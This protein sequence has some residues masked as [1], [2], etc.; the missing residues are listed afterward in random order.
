MATP[1]AAHVLV[2]DDDPIV[3]QLVTESLRLSGHHTT[4]VGGA[5]E[6]LNV[7][8]QVEFDLVLTDALVGA[9]AEPEA[10]RWENLEYVRR[11]AGHARVVIFS[12]HSAEYFTGYR[13]RGFSG[14]LLKPFDLDDLLELVD[15]A[16]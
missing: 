3:A 6:A 12:A 16:E 7:L 4:C 2:V 14:L 13:E 11:A 15:R 5:A 1:S 9:G 10:D 8:A